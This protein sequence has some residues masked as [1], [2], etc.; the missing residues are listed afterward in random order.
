MCLKDLS[1]SL[2]NRFLLLCLLSFTTLPLYADTYWNQFRGPNGQGTLDGAEPPVVLDVEKNMMWKTSLPPGHSSPAIWKDRIFLTAFENDQLS[3]I[4]IDRSSG[5]ITWKRSTPYEAIKASNSFARLHS[6]SSP[7]APTVCVDANHVYTYFPSFGAI[8]YSHDGNQVWEVNIPHNQFAWGSTTSPSVFLGTLFIIRDC[9]EKDASYLLAL[10]AKTGEEQWKTP[11]PFS[12]ASFST[13]AILS[14]GDL[15]ELIVLGTGRLSAYNMKTGEENW[16]V[17]GLGTSAISVP[18][19]DKDRIYV[20]MK[21][22]VGFDVAYDSEKAWEYFMTFDAN[23]NQALEFSELTDDMKIPQRP[24]LPYDN[25][26]FGMKIRA[27]QFKRNDQNQDGKVT[28]DE[29]KEKMEENTKNMEASFSCIKVHT[30]SEN[31]AKSN[32]LWTQNRFL[33]EI[34]SI[35]FYKDRLYSIANGGIFICRNKDTGEIIHRAR[36]N[37]PGMYASSPIAAND[38]IYLCSKQGIVSV[39]KADDSFEIVTRLDLDEYIYA[40]PALHDNEIYIRTVNHLY[41]FGE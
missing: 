1:V 2:N 34:P 22:L 32:I 37:A 20:S 16:Y 9:M 28:F 41:A 33:T 14:I 12:M 25:P 26:G 6:E 5:E 40:T 30:A 18:L 10:D 36:I 15:D 24:E 21:A 4:A 17:D 29:F 8:C 38:H 31:G 11:R 39:M 7:A 23:K 3:T 27:N 19:F 13:P 35:L